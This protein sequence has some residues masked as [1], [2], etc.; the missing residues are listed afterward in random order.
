MIYLHQSSQKNDLNEIRRSETKV[1]LFEIKENFV[2]PQYTFKLAWKIQILWKL[3]HL[4]NFK[5]KNGVERG[6]GISL[7]IIIPSKFQAKNIKLFR[8]CDNRHGIIDVIYSFSRAGLQ[9]S[10]LSVYN[11]ITRAWISMRN[12]HF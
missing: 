6:K 9:C 3:Y 1:F 4:N 11:I 2:T 10:H 7:F 8:S 5:D 12:E